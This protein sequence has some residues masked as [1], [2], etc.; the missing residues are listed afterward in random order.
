M[1]L[2]LI[3]FFSLELILCFVTSFLKNALLVISHL[4]SLFLS[5]LLSLHPFQHPNVA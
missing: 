1:G 4:T 2:G 5:S 3:S